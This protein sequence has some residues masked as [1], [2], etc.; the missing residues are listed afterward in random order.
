MISLYIQAASIFLKQLLTSESSVFKLH[1]FKIKYSVSPQYEPFTERR[2]T[3]SYADSYTQGL[4]PT[5][6]DWVGEWGTKQQRCTHCFINS[7]H[8]ACLLFLSPKLLTLLQTRRHSQRRMMQWE[9]LCPP[10]S[11][12]I[13]PSYLGA[14]ASHKPL[15]PTQAPPLSYLASFLG[16]EAQDATLQNFSSSPQHKSCRVQRSFL[17]WIILKL[18]HYICT[19]SL[20]TPQPNKCSCSGHPTQRWCVLPPRI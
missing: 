15:P 12:T 19:I 5:R 6:V 14:E 8:C 11:E 16:A 3:I 2:A 7:R 17:L 13:R 20:E 18:G 10:D 1:L 4:C 9:C